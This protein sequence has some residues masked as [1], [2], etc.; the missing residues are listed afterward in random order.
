LKIRGWTRAAEIGGEAVWDRARTFPI[1]SCD[2]FDTAIRRVLARPEDVLL[3][4]GARARAERLIT[5]EPDAF[6][7]YRATAERTARAAAEASG[8]DEVQIAEIYAE[9]H[10]TGIVTDPV[11]A[12]RVEFEAE[13]AVCRP[14]EAVQNEL[15]ARG[16]ADP[17]A[18]LV[19]ASDSVLPGAW[20]AELL[21]SCGYGEGCEV[22]ASA[23]LRRGKHTGRLFP[24][25]I[26]ALGCKA[27]DI[28]HIGDNPVS[29]IIRARAHGIAA[30]HL[31]RARPDPETDNA[32]HYVVRLADS[33]QRAIAAEGPAPALGQAAEDGRA[34]AAFTAPLLIGFSLFILAEARR[35]GVNRIYFLARDGHLPLA[36]IRR[37]LA[38]QGEAE[39]FE[40]RYLHVSR[41]AVV[42]TPGVAG[43]L[44][45]SGF[46][47][48]GARLI[49]DL[50]WRGSIQSAMAKRTG[51]PE[52]DLIGC[53]VGLWA[54]ALRPGLNPGNAVGYLFAFGHPAPI[55][56]CVRDAY[57][58]LEMMFSAPHGT[59]LRYEPA[60]DGTFRP[61]L[62]TESGPTGDIRRAAFA[63]MEAACL[64]TFDALDSILGGAWPEGI[65]AWSALSP[66][67]SLLTR[68]TRAEFELVNRVPFLDTEEGM[69]RPAVNPVPL[70][71]ALRH[72]HKAL[73]RLNH[74]PWRA[75]AVRAVL[76]W[77]MRGVS[78]EVL[79]DR[80]TRVLR[81][82]ER[83]RAMLGLTKQ[84]G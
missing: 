26:E 15:R 55:A 78:Y 77:P 64:E 39:Q 13:C 61:V 6:A 17:R 60:E 18:R 3:A 75:G 37:L 4:A 83:I 50:G 69:L 45:Q 38:R 67:E 62:L 28:L 47:R 53:Y 49:V 57:A 76:P 8:Y 1:L 72:P 27:S 82:G 73:R 81:L 20:L 7:V 9:L 25:M 31:P 84:D 11:R 33:R 79:N 66:M 52:S 19:F 40:L 43:Y 58:V 54:D 14:I 51:L 70:H 34:L 80:A 41:H 36:I 44:E 12:A 23:D 46:S 59:V 71:E 35:R 5:C 32:R 22:F 21:Q 56:A 24:A 16:A 48:P 10:A 30:H 2:I 42:S 63:E 65:D 68:P 74:S 29:D